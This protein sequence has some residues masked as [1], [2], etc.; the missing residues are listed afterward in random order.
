MENQDSIECKDT[1]LKVLCFKLYILYDFH[2]KI[3]IMQI[4]QKL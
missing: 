4:V 3:N 2:G 1:G